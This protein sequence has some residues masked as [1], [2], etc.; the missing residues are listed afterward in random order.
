MS[1]SS[2][3]RIIDVLLVRKRVNSS[4]FST[5]VGSSSATPC[6]LSVTMS[7]AE[8]ERKPKKPHYVP[9]PPGKPFRYQCFQCPFTCNQKSHL[10]NH[11]K[12][13]LCHASISVS[14]GR[15][16]PSSP[17][18]SRPPDVC[19]E[20]SS[21]VWRPQVLRPHGPG[22]V[23]RSPA[24]LQNEPHLQERAE[25]F[26]CHP[27]FR[28]HAAPAGFLPLYPHYQ[29]YI[30]GLC[31]Q[32]LFPMGEE[33]LRYYNLIPAHSYGPP[34][35]SLPSPY[36]V[37]DVGSAYD[38]YALV[39]NL[40]EVQ[41]SPQTG[42]SAAGS[43]DRPNPSH[44]SQHTQD[45]RGAAPASQSEE[46]GGAIRAQEDR[47]LPERASSASRKM[48]RRGNDSKNDR[49]DEDICVPLNLSR[50]DSPLN[51]SVMTRSDTQSPSSLMNEGIV[52]TV[53][54][55]EDDHLPVEKTAAFAL[56]Q[57]AQSS[58]SHLSRNISYSDSSVCQEQETNLLTSARSPASDV[59]EAASTDS[60]PTPD[61]KPG[62]AVEDSAPSAD[63][64]EVSAPSSHI[65]HQTWTKRQGKHNL[66]R[67][68]KHN[69]R[70]RICH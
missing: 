31:P 57:L 24:A 1:H 11:M 30:L 36:S 56:C 25:G 61:V 54:S 12:H 64:T 15:R 62:G 29:P 43:P 37:M 20:T 2:L 60:K 27:G 16:E 13:N 23:W 8:K 55:Q 58:V 39:V 51:L 44:D 7:I 22:S 69:L 17:E 6:A 59:S 65:P 41:V 45:E 5:V 70:K 33:C 21:P 14:S 10:F 38:P 50:R 47:R 63:A 66:K 26:P 68:Q 67:K 35:Q 32:M 52:G 4:S 42:R 46:R 9:R 3:C 34:E 28:S 18:P 40:K 49:F 48:E 53:T 19:E